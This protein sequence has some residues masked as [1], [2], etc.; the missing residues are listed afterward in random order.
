[1]HG[2]R[3]RKHEYTEGER[4]LEEVKQNGL[5]L[6]DVPARYRADHEIV[7]AAVQQ[8]GYALQFAAEECKADRDIVLAAVKQK[9]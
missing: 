7:L 3:K 9:A 4:H 8:N 6:R 5:N 1:M 2:D